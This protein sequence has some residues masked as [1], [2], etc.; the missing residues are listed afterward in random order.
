[1]AGKEI[2]I[3]PK[4]WCLSILVSEKAE[5]RSESGNFFIS[6]STPHFSTKCSFF[7]SRSETRSWIGVARSWGVKSLLRQ[8]FVKQGEVKI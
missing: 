5:G 7:I 3:G 1:M 2:I 4:R 6:R 8:G